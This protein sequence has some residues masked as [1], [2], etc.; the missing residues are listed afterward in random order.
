MYHCEKDKIQKYC[1][2]GEENGRDYDQIVLTYIEYYHLK[3][4]RYK[5]GFY[6]FSLI[7]IIMIGILPVLQI[8]GIST[9][10]P[11][12]IT[13][14]SSGIIV[15]ESITEL[16]RLR[17][18][19]ILYR[20]TCNR[21]MTVQRQYMRSRGKGNKRMRKYIEAVEAVINEEGNGWSKISKDIKGCRTDGNRR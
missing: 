3:A 18:K 15:V 6:M 10:V 17:E 16:W 19:W 7:K 9:S 12:V 13:A 2:G 8:A 1:Y 20:N 11:W 5:R 21:L 14:F 4:Q